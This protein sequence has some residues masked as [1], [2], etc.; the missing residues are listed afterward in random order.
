M[1][2]RQA[3]AM[4]SPGLVVLLGSLTWFV[5][6]PKGDMR[7]HLVDRGIRLLDHLREKAKF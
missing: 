3:L 7:Q 6:D 1:T 2:R 4:S 5:L